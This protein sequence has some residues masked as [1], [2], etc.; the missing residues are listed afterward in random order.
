MSVVYLHTKLLSQSATET[1]GKRILRGIAT[2]MGTDRVGD[3]VVSRGARFVLPLVLLWQHAQAQPIGSVTRAQVRDNEIR[4][5]AEL[6]RGVP[7]AD[8]AWSLL[9]AGTP[10]GFSVG[11]LP[12]KSEPLP[13]GARKYTE[14]EWTELS[15]VSVNAARGARIEE[16]IGKAVVRERPGDGS[17]RLIKPGIPLVRGGSHD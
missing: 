16:V 13:T 14:W 3:V 4:V 9:K 17:V 8:R 6:V 2:E 7:E 15:V 10:L 5:E 12:I 1:D 11:F